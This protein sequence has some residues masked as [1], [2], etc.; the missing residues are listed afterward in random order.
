MFSW[1]TALKQNTH[2][3]LLVKDRRAGSRYQLYGSPVEIEN[4]LN[5]IAEIARY[6]MDE[7]NLWCQSIK[8]LH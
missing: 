7:T 2:C 1:L 3:G 5:W 8:I 4:K 6:V